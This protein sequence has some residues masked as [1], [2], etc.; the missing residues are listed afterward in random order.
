MTVSQWEDTAG[1]TGLE[2][3][4]QC[5]NNSD[6]ALPLP[7]KYAEKVAK[8]LL[9]LC[10]TLLISAAWWRGILNTWTQ[11]KL[12]HCE[13]LLAQWLCLLGVS[14]LWNCCSGATQLY[15]QDVKAAETSL[16]AIL[17]AGPV[18]SICAACN[19][20]SCVYIWNLKDVK[21]AKTS[22]R[23]LLQAR[24]LESMGAVC[25]YCC[26]VYICNLKMRKQFWLFAVR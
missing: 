17:R 10:C 8:F 14:V 20:Y 2:C 6:R 1:Y 23:E 3:T 25:N 24:S 7:F 13:I 18:G 16:C 22:Q 21:A 5:L 12:F 15:S 11:L 4:M 26:C 9:E 19:Y